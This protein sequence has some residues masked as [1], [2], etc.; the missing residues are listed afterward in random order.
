MARTTAEGSV[1]S[2]SSLMEQLYSEVVALSRYFAF[3]GYVKL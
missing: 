3:C 1:S 2:K